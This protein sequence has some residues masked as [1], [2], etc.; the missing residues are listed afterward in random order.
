MGIDV[1]SLIDKEMEDLER[2]QKAIDEQAALLEKQLRSVMET[3]NSNG[4][5]EALMAKWFLFV[6]KKN[7]LLRRQMQL[8]ILWVVTSYWVFA[9]IIIMFF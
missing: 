6:N 7:A 2:E 9:L 3:G 4:E 1:H 5:E 8:N